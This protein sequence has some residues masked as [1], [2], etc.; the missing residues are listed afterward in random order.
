MKT[1]QNNNHNNPAPPPPNKQNTRHKSN[2]ALCC[3][4][5]PPRS[6]ITKVYVNTGFPGGASGKE[7]AS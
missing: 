1:Q 2:V 7:S 5:Y 4:A 6:L 3:T